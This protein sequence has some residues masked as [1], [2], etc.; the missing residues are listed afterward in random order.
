FEEIFFPHVGEFAQG[1]IFDGV[2][3]VWD[4]LKDLETLVRAALS[5]ADAGDPLESV[6]GLKV[7]TEEPGILVERWIKLERPIVSEAMGVWIGAGTVLEPTAIIKGPAVIGGRSE[8]R[9]GAYVRGNALIGECCVI[10]H[11]TEIKNS[12]LMNHVEAGHFNYV[13]DSI[14]GSYV[15]LGAGSRLA[16]VQFRSLEEKKENFINPIE[17]PMEKGSV[18]TGLSKFGAILGDNVEVGCNA[19]ICP[20]ALIG[21]DNWIYPNCTVPKGFHPPGHFIAPPDHRP[22]SR[23]K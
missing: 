5:R 7:D 12:V 15:N 2:E 18:P 20:G 8:I 23:A 4:P 10:G 19:V 11:C 6:Q 22:K 21:K 9:P 13:G 16:N 14:L 17:I 3:Q 1:D